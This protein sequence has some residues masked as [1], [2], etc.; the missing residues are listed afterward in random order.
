MTPLKRR[1][2][3]ADIWVAKKQP[4]LFIGVCLLTS[5]SVY[6][7]SNVQTQRNPRLPAV[8]AELSFEVVPNLIETMYTQTKCAIMVNGKITEWFEVLVGVRQGC[9]LEG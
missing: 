8:T 6:M 4:L 3:L 5:L 1:L 7:T 2:L 9:L